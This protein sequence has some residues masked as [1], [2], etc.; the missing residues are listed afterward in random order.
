MGKEK[1]KRSTTELFQKRLVVL[2][3]QVR[4]NNK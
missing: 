1:L 4:E 3:R 2:S